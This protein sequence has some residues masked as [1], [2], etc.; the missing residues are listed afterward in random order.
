AS[1]AGGAGGSVGMGGAST[2][3]VGGID[4]GM[5]ADG[6]GMTGTGGTTGG[7]AGDS[8]P[9]AGCGSP[10]GLT[11]GRASIDVGGKMREYILLVPDNYDPN[12]PYRLIFGW[13]PWGGSAQQTESMG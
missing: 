9:S 11:S 5:S 13:H 3:G 2:A 4:G 10:A 12:H 1:A 8:A 6:A 7:S